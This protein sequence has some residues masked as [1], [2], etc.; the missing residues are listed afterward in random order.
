MGLDQYVFCFRGR[1]PRKEVDFERKDVD[2]FWYWRKHPN[3]E[4]W[5][6]N[7]YRE[8]GGDKEFN[9]C[10]VWLSKLDIERLQEDIRNDNLP[11]TQGFFFGESYPSEKER[12]LEFC[13]EALQ[14][15]QQGFQLYY[16]SWW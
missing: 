12:D 7:L 16:S 2:R 3:I 4:G 8:K 11:E 10:N 13:I 5:M 14:K 9:C 1:K 15:I 6:E